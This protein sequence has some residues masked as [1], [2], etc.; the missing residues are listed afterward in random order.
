MSQ[1]PHNEQ[2]EQNA[3][4]QNYGQGYGQNPDYAQNPQQNYG[5]PGY[6]Q[7]GAQSYYQPGQQP[8]TGPQASTQLPEGVYGEGSE[9]FWRASPNDRTTSLWVGIGQLLTGWIVPLILFL[10]KKDESAF[11]REHSRQ[12]LNFGITI[13][14]ANA[15]ISIITVVTFGIGGI[16]YF[17]TAIVQIVFGI[18]QAVAANKG[19]GY[20]YPMTIQFIK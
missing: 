7:P 4:G 2:P 14:I 13:V 9:A 6:G 1:D 10:V 12:A 18:L 8:F 16:L 19:Q 20:R 11:V 3:L 15:A 17:A 5:Q